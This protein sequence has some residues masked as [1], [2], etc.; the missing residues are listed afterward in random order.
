MA[1]GSKKWGLLL[2]AVAVPAAA[3]QVVSTGGQGDVAV[4]IYSGELALVTDTRQTNL[5][6]GAAKL[7]FPDVS[8]RIRPETVSLVGT[9]LEIV[10]QNF[11]F[12][13]L[14]PTAMM[15]KAVGQEITLIRTNP[16]TGAELRE[17]AKVLAVNGG[18]VL[19]VGGRIEILRDDNLPVRVIFDGIPANLRARPTLS[20][21]VDSKSA[22]TRP[23]TLRYLS[24]GLSWRADYVAL[25]D[26]GA[27]AMDVQGWVTLRNNSGTGFANAKLLLVASEQIGIRR[28]SRSGDGEPAALT[29][30]GTEAAKAEALADM[31]A[32]PMT[33]RTTIASAQQK[34]IAFLDAMGVP[35]TRGYSASVDRFRTTD[36]AES[37]ISTYRFSTGKGGVGDAMPAGSVRLYVKDARGAAQFVGESYIGHTSTG[38]TLSLATG[39]AFDVKY[40]AVIDK[41][42][43]LTEED[44]TR[45]SSTRVTKNGV[46]TVTETDVKRDYWRTH[47]RYI[48]TNARPTPVTVEFS[49]HGLNSYNN[50]TRVPFESLPAE[51]EQAYDSR[52]WL[53]TVPANGRTELTVQY[54]TLN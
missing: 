49:Q 29:S 7:E 31:H 23:L 26:E 14:S 44:W 21:T 12:D 19:D 42:E 47:M 50:D 32:Y 9:G 41:R 2:A 10:E 53:V 28:G 35:A 36:Q 27:K 6:A 33:E 54:D 25:Y 1:G 45:S 37:A 15:Q 38:S 48:F 52:K 16:A 5:P 17:R 43:K 46:V 34:Q 8:T 40:Q 4:T 18:V 13:L 39:K 20:V 51:K 11:D 30:A 3:Q 24:E 22:G